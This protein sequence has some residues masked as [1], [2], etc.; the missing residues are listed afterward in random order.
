M[1]LWD[2]FEEEFELKDT[3][4]VVGTFNLGRRSAEESRTAQPTKQYGDKLDT[5]RELTQVEQAEIIKADIERL[6]ADL[7]KI[8]KEPLPPA[9]DGVMTIVLSV[10]AVAFLSSG[11]LLICLGDMGFITFIAMAM[12]ILFALGGLGGIFSVSD[13]K[14]EA[15]AKKQ[16]RIDAVRELLEIKKRTYRRVNPDA[17]IPGEIR[18]EKDSDEDTARILRKRIFIIV[19]IAAAVIAV[20]LIGYGLNRENVENDETVQEENP[21]AA[22][23]QTNDADDQAVEEVE[24]D[25][26]EETGLSEEEKEAYYKKGKKYLNQ[27]KY[28]KAYRAFMK[29][30]GYSDSGFRA[31]I[32]VDKLIK[33]TSKATMYGAWRID[34]GVLRSVYSSAVLLDINNLKFITGDIKGNLLGIIDSS[35]KFSLV[36]K[37][38][39]IDGQYSD[40][41]RNIW[42]NVKYVAVADSTKWVN[43]IGI[44]KT[45][46]LVYKSGTDLSALDSWRNIR[47]LSIYNRY[48]AGLDRY[49]NVKLY[50]FLDKKR[51][52]VKWEDI[53]QIGLGVHDKL[54]GLSAD[55]T[56]NVMKIS[57]VE[58][59]YWT[60]SLGKLTKFALLD[61]GNCIVGLKSNG[62]LV[63]SE[64]LPKKIRKLKNVVDVTA[65]GYDITVKLETGEYKG[66]VLNRKDDK[67]VL[68]PNPGIGAITI[69]PDYTYHVP[70][71][72][73]TNSDQSNTNSYDD[74]YNDVWDDDDYDDDRYRTDSEYEH[75]VDDALDEYDE[76]YGEEWEEGNY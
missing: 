47:A 16:Q 71:N 10:L 68:Y 75:G 48:I 38:Y 27:H 57:S 64:K 58:S 50:D 67:Y 76:E 4:N 20:C 6:E 15:K 19:I 74:G 36:N 45:G 46:S 34:G 30:D 24:A 3:V 12:G 22:N 66:F 65:D 7:E 52:E 40:V 49:G 18:N 70:A 31:S 51:I 21:E 60:S 35:G 41:E 2:D 25:T 5:L 9:E 14:K 39:V 26:E 72:N 17:D 1:S 54:Y 43:A 61:S 23:T 33:K 63:S 73:S 69:D 29:A 44:K 13:H 11:I 32:C 8:K 59:D 37:R 62:T 55:G 53:I 28:R 56:L 42:K